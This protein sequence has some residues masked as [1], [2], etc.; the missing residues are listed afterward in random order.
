M[1]K[2]HEDLCEKVIQRFPELWMTLEV[3]RIA[4]DKVN[5]PITCYEDFLCLAEE[6]TDY[7][8]LG[9]Q[10]ISFKQLRKYFPD[11]F[12]PIDNED[13]LISKV[14]LAFLWGKRAHSL[15]AELAYTSGKEEQNA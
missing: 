5:Y 8:D 15:E 1:K 12:F 6:G 2:G 4:R 14:L 10:R 11:A 7:C 3:A 13:D 9:E